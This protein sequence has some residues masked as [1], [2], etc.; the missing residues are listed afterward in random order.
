MQTFR[1]EVS[2]DMHYVVNGVQSPRIYLKVGETCRFIIDSKD[3]PFYVTSD[4]LGGT[5]FQRGAEMTTSPI[6]VGE[7]DFTAKPEHVG[8]QLF[9][10]CDTKTNMGYKI[11]VKSN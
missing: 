4:P 11:H 6:E 3:Y 8:K 2:D 7:L 5:G 9:Y 1:V 10:Q